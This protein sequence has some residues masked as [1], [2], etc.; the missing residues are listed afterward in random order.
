MLS[1]E[2]RLLLIGAK[3]ATRAAEN[4]AVRELVHA[5]IDWT[6]LAHRMVEHGVISSVAQMLLRVAPDLMPED[7]LDALRTV[8]A[9]TR[10]RNLAL[11]DEMAALIEGLAAAGI[12]AI[13]FKG[14]ILAIRAHGNLGLRTFRDID[15]LVRDADLGAAVVALEALG[16]ARRGP[17]TAAQFD[18][19][20]HVQG[21]EIVFGAASGTAVEPHARLTSREMA[22]D[23]DHEG[24]WKRAQWAL[25]N[26]RRMLLPAAALAGHSFGAAIPPDVAA[27]GQADRVI[28]ARMAQIVANWNAEQPVGPADNS[29]LSLALL[30]LHDR[31]GQRFSYVVRTL[32]RRTPKG[33]VPDHGTKAVEPDQ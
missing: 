18:L 4:A 6:G 22:L 5:G 24:L 14:S 3:V 16:S 27:A 12:G 19:I 31:F 17:L 10:R 21:Q 25:L 2:L 11:F 20:Q 32:L 7:L 28:G 29:P 9:T 33:R 30:R 26:N 15:V 8:L 1:P 13:P 23:I